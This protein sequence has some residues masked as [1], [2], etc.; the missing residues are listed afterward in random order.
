MCFPSAAQWF[1]D[2]DDT[3]PFSSQSVDRL[4]AEE[5]LLTEELEHKLDYIARGDD[6]FM[7]V[8]DATRLTADKDQA[9][10]GNMPSVG[11]SNIDVAIDAVVRKAVKKAE[12]FSSGDENAHETEAARKRAISKMKKLVMEILDRIMPTAHMI[13]TSEVGDVEAA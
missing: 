13:G 7:S 1:S 10:F 5:D 8:P 4:A 2:L 11:A 3:D 6:D 12:L 9:N